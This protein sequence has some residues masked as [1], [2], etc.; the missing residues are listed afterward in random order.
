[1]GGGGGQGAGG[2]GGG[3]ETA[4]VWEESEF[5]QALLF[6]PGCCLFDGP[7]QV[8]CARVWTQPGASQD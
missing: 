5:S 8:V 7:G 3:G 4:T 6:S 1:M 2:A